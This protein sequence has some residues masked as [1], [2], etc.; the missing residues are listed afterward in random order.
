MLG[1]GFARCFGFVRSLQARLGKE[2][3]YGGG[4]QEDIKEERCRGVCRG[5][6]QYGKNIEEEI[7][8]ECRGS[9]WREK[10]QSGLKG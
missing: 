1:L 2:K 7:R 4:D 3:K 10:G 8:Y 5:R 9:V 6:E